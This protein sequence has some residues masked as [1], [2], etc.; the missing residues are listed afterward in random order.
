MYNTYIFWDHSTQFEDRD[1][2]LQLLGG[3]PSVVRSLGTYRYVHVLTA[4]DLAPQAAVVLVQR[5]E[6][7]VPGHGTSGTSCDTESR[8]VE[9]PAF[10]WPT[11]CIC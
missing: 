6:D 4:G 10:H 9:T 7:V 11:Q 2:S 5:Q 1:Q 3:D 8:D